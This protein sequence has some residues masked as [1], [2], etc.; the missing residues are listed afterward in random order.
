LSRYTSEDSLTFEPLY[1]DPSQ[2][3]ENFVIDRTT[4]TLKLNAPPPPTLK[5][6][7][8]RPVI[9]IMGLVQLNAGDYLIAITNMVRIGKI[10]GHEVFRMTEYCVYA[11][12]RTTTHLS[13]DLKT[14]DATYLSMLD[15]VLK[16]ECY[17]FSYTLDLTNSLQRQHSFFRDPSNISPTWARSDD[18]FFW[19]LHLSRKMID[20]S[21][22]PGNDLSNFILPVICGYVDIKTVRVTPDR[23]IT[24]ALVSRRSRYRAGTRLNTR[25]IDEVGNVANF[26]ETEQIVHIHETNEKF[27]YLQTRGSIPVFWQQFPNVKYS[28]KPTL[29]RDRDS[30]APFQ[31][32]FSEQI[33]RYGKQIA[34]NLVNKKGSEKVIADEYERQMSALQDAGNARYVH[35]DFHHECRK[36]QWDRIS[37]LVEE[38]QTDLQEQGYTRIDGSNTLLMWQKSMIRTNC[39]DCLDRTNVVQS[40]LARKKIEEQFRDLA[41]WPPGITNIEGIP[42]LE[43][44]FRNAWAT[45]GNEVAK[46]YAGSGAMKVDFTRTGKRT[47]MGLLEDGKNSLIRYVKNNWLDGWRQDAIDLFVGVYEVR[48]GVRPTRPPKSNQILLAVSY[49]KSDL[50]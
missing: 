6:E 33:R 17:Y 5:H 20:A 47:R 14:D 36:M 49:S 3:R 4:G 27:S 24:F 2:L 37:L 40:V 26:V 46:Q 9:G 45:N 28:P 13:P 29:E 42:E 43:A 31:K 15:D 48:P 23:T 50:A 19:N 35:F 25:G 38:I 11:V 7:D 34:V 16:S 18:R 12:P 1:A 44:V 22:Q 8:V 10:F 32:H 41:L 39:M 30:A 21:Q